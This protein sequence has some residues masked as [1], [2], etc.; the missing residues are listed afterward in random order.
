MRKMY[1]SNPFLTNFL[2]FSAML[3]LA[4]MVGTSSVSAQAA[5]VDQTQIGFM[6]PNL[7]DMLTFA[8]RGFFV[9]V[10]L[11]T[12]FYLLIGAFSWI[13]SGGKEEKVAE[14]RAK[15]QAAVVGIVLVFA[16]LAVITTLEQV[17]FARK[18][19]F[20]ISCAATVPSAVK[21]GVVNPRAPTTYCPA[22][23]KVASPVGCCPAAVT[24]VGYKKVNGAYEAL[25]KTV[26]CDS[27]EK[28]GTDTTVNPARTG[29]C[30]PK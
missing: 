24:H 1:S 3:G 29:A 28:T 11:A 27:A 30:I 13:T 2:V 5:Q 9:V 20:G 26:C 15:I 21:T 8:V 19:C 16:V 18:L 4:A 12:A 6:L 17:V 10:G 23:T 25:P 22:G 7:G 14:A